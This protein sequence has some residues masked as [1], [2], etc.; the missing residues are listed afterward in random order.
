[1]RVLVTGNRGYIGVVLVPLLQEAGHTVVGLDNLLFDDCVFGKETDE[2]YGPVPTLAKDVR[3]VTREDMDGFEAVVHLAALS[4][5]PLG[6]LNSDI[7]F[8]INHRGAVTVARAAKDAGVPRFVQ[9]STCSLYGA[10][11]DNLLDESAEFHPVTPYGRA[12]VLAERDI[13]ALA[14]D[15][16]TP[17]FL[18]NATAYGVS[19]RLRGDLVV[20]NLV[21]Y[22]YTTGEVLMKSD[23][24]PWRPLVHIQD[25]SRAIVATLGAPRALVHNEA[26]NVGATQENYR[27]RDV[28]AIVEDVVAGSRIAFADHASPD[29][30][31]Y[32]VNCDKLAATLPDARPRWTV[33]KGVEE[34]HAAFIQEGLVLEDLTGP[35]LQRIRHVLSLFE[36]GVLGRDLR[37]KEPPVA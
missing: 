17:T 3:D 20:N 33:R 4:N 23:G 9:S 22:A 25:I 15:S 19:S 26:F 31:N 21:G 10:H 36:T 37:W 27:V 28:A 6:D 7:T 2:A 1:M 32:R 30:R 34:L 24:T 16:F 13:A 12:K 14:D 18:R 8:D 11:G 35:R 29:L 5:D